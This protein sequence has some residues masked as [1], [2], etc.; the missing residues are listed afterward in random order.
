MDAT[1]P[2]LNCDLTVNQVVRQWP[3]TAVVFN[4]VGIDSCCGGSLTV[5][6]AAHYEQVDANV[7]CA[8]LHTA[9]DAAA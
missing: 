1:I 2:A 5:T 8:A 7:L 3:E 9:V 6:Q 4:L